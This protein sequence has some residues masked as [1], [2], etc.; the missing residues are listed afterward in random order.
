M[1]RASLRRSS[2]HR[3]VVVA[4]FT[5]VH[6]CL[7]GALAYT[8]AHVDQRSLDIDCLIQFCTAHSA[9]LLRA[10]CKFSFAVFLLFLSAPINVTC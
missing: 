4:I 3:L 2:A 5:L 10:S 8:S 9:L 6:A 7:F 1:S